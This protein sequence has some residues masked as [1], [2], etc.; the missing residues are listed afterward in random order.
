MCKLDGSAFLVQD[1]S[2][3]PIVCTARLRNSQ[4]V[5]AGQEFVIVP[6]SA[7]PHDV[8]LRTH[9]PRRVIRR[10]S[11]FLALSLSVQL[12][13]CGDEAGCP[14]GTI[15][16]G[17]RCV[18]GMVDGGGED[19]AVTPNLDRDAEPEG[20]AEAGEDAGPGEELCVPTLG[21]DGESPWEDC[22]NGQD[23]DCDGKIDEGLVEVCNGRDDDCDGE[24]DEATK[25]PFYSDLD[26]DGFGAGEPIYAC[27]APA[28]TSSE[29][30]DCDDGDESRSPG[31]AEVCDGIDNDCHGGPDDS[32]ACVRAQTTA[33]T[34]S[35]GS[36]GQ[37]TCT[38]DCT[39]PTDVACVAPAETC[40]LVD[41]DCDG[42]ADE[43]F[44]E[45]KPN[46][47]W[48]TASKTG[49]GL[50]TYA[51]TVP[52]DPDGAWVIRDPWD[53][54]GIYADAL[55]RNG[56]VIA[57]V[58]SL[59]AE[60]TNM[61]NVFAAGD[62]KWVVL[63]LVG[64]LGTVVQL[65]RA[66]NF[67]LV[68]AR[69]IDN[70]FPVEVA[71]RS[72]GDLVTMAVV[73]RGTVYDEERSYTA[74]MLSKLVWNGSTW[75]P[76]TGNAVPEKQ[77]FSGIVDAGAMVL[78]PV[79]CLKKWIV[80]WGGRWGS[81]ENGY[82]YLV[83]DS[84]TLPQYPT[85]SVAGAHTMTGFG[86]ASNGCDDTKS[87]LVVGTLA[88]DASTSSQM[89]FLVN[90]VTGGLSWAGSIAIGSSAY[91]TAFTKHGNIWYAF[92]S[93]F[94]GGNTGPQ[95]RE[96]HWSDSSGTAREITLVPAGA[97]NPSAMA[98]AYGRHISLFSL[99]SVLAATISS[100]TALKAPYAAEHPESTDVAMGVTYL[101]GCPQ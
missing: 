76:P 52:R 67:S 25:L 70:R 4:H 47:H 66:T 56:N 8:A 34:T 51:D 90:Q 27:M 30:T 74:T 75:S 54:N 17:S 10:T 61:S 31:V 87:E 99:G 83:D 95:L 26:G 84:F 65:R 35:C 46:V 18:A 86:L 68:A 97:P 28:A 2:Q 37:G 71:L 78:A 9:S 98:V 7:A 40:N 91:H 48:L 20:E 33:C 96:V 93:H 53:G 72:S 13:A 12:G 45:R 55:D 15:K 50:Q 101:V 6:L 58:P 32:F 43:G 44:L 41:D 23:D 29:S 77:L 88:S 89:R 39:L 22:S 11:I 81:S 62:G 3:F 85:I 80:G 73:T 82:L 57:S 19:A 38:E 69:T 59:R 92:S 42:Y 63:T 60:T 49:S 21:P 94:S 100:H 5:F 1:T 36:T 64:P 16:R 14:Q 79:P 24:T